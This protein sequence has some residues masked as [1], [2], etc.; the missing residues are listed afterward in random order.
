MAR[1]GVVVVRA[2]RGRGP[3]AASVAHAG[4]RRANGG[5]VGMLEIGDR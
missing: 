2:P 1:N 3:A 5:S 4:V